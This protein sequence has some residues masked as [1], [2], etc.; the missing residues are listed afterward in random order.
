MTDA[1][2]S[3]V[4]AGDRVAMRECIERYSR[5]VWSLAV[6]LSPSRADAEDAVQEIFVS[7]WQNASR[8]EPSR[9]SEATFITVVARRRLIDRMRRHGKAVGAGAED[10]DADAVPA[11][12]APAIELTEE[13]KA[14]RVAMGQLPADR[15]RVVAM[16]VV[17]GLTQEEIAAQTNMPL[18]TVKSHLRRG[19]LAVREALVG[20][21]A[22]NAAMR[23]VGT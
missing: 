7:L 14:A 22:S 20:T 9:A 16:S 12:D 19:L 23:K 1:Y 4:A 11:P 18:G 8:Y 17:E 13:A 15:R 2:L 10:F 6:R 5:L 3:R 21:S